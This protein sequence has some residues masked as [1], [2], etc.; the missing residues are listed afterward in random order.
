M[1]TLTK[2]ER[3]GLEDIFL[4]IHTDRTKYTKIKEISSLLV[5]T[6]ISFNASK[7]LK[8]AKLGL[9]ESKLSQFITLFIKKKKNLS[10]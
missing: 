1:S 7:F 9:K 4:S 6:T 3:D 5:S 8:V 10:K 2:Q